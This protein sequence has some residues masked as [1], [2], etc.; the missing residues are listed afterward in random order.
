MSAFSKVRT[1]ALGRALGGP[2]GVAVDGGVEPA[3]E[4]ADC[5]T[6]GAASTVIGGGGQPPRGAGRTAVGGGPVNPLSCCPFSTPPPPHNFPYP[7]PAILASGVGR[8]ANVKNLHPPG[9]AP[10]GN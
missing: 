3:G 1:T 2:G 9:R 5:A 10:W 4:S 7:P 8:G 6:I